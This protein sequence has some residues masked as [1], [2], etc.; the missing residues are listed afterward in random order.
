MLSLNEVKKIFSSPINIILVVAVT[1]LLISTTYLSFNRFK[2]TDAPTSSPALVTQN[3]DP[4]NLSVLISKLPKDTQTFTLAYD[5][6]TQTFNITPKTTDLNLA[7]KELE[8]FLK[9]N[10]IES[11][12]IK[13]SWAPLPGSLP[14]RK[15]TN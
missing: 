9:K 2:K 8:V 10:S 11:S 1:L 7:K 5:S 6:Y 3:P 14:N 12:Q 13:I 15:P 4:A